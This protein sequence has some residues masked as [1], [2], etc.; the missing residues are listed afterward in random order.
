MSRSKN[1]ELSSWKDVLVKLRRIETTWRGISLSRVDHETWTEA[2]LLNAMVLHD[3]SN[4]YEGCGSH[5]DHVLWCINATH[6]DVSE[7]ASLLSDAICML[8]DIV[9]GNQIRYAD[10][11]RQLQVKHPNSGALLAPIKQAIALFLAEP[12][13]H[14]FYP[15]YQFL[16]FMT[17][18]SLEDIDMSEELELEF[19][20]NEE[21]VSAHHTPPFLIARLNEIMKEWLCDWKLGNFLPSHGP[22]SVAELRGD[23]S[24]DSKFR[25]LRPNQMIRVVFSMCAGL[26]VS[27]FLPLQIP[28]TTSRTSQIVF[29]PKNMKTK[30][31][32]SKEPATFMYFQQGVRRSTGRYFRSN[33]D[34]RAHIDLEDQGKQ[35]EMAL[36]AS[37]TRMFAT[38]DLSAASDSV[39]YELVKGVFTGTPLYPY[40]VAL[41]TNAVELPSGKVLKV[42]KFAPMGSALCFPIETLI[43][44]AICECTVRYV[45]HTTGQ[46]YP[47]YTVY[48]DDIIIADPCFEDLKALLTLCGF[49]INEGKSYA[50]NSRFRESCGCDAYDGVDVTPMKIGRRFSSRQCHI[51]S[52]S[53]FGGLKD[54]ANDCLT[55]EFP[56]LRQYLVSRLIHDTGFVPMFTQDTNLGLYSPQPTNFHLKE[57]W[58]NRLQRVE[59]K[60]TTIHT[61]VSKDAPITWDN[62]S[63]EYRSMEPRPDADTIRL[64]QWYYLTNF[65]QG[66][67]LGDEYCRPVHTGSAGAY[68]AKRWNVK[69]M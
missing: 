54:M 18:L 66:D 7:M 2:I 5:R 44:A 64:Y 56:L 61:Y 43:F 57:R 3:L 48:G 34:L 10:F 24:L 9:P 38:V 26:D 52:T 4:R 58:N 19:I 62:A 45:R 51:R 15:A 40:L 23:T 67:P 46:S 36:E 31:V 30:R 53:V 41:R 33:P 49:T 16:S 11:K 21:R 35:R 20:R 37:R 68:L 39:S 28:G 14:T 32:I 47:R 8:R 12:T 29:V 50:G 42:A 6:T 1:R 27:T 59:V 63:K 55:Y 60:A 69:P 65:R 25:E 17:H 22:G 13:P